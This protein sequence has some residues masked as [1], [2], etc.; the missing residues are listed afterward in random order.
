[1]PELPSTSS[2]NPSAHESRDSSQIEVATLECPV[3]GF[4]EGYRISSAAQLCP[5]CA[6]ERHDR[7]IQGRRQRAE[8][9]LRAEKVKQLHSVA[10][11]PKL[12]K[13][14][15]LADYQVSNPGQRYAMAICKAFVDSW[16]E[17]CT[18]GGT[19]LLL[20][21]CGTGKTHLACAIANTVIAE[22]MSTVCFGTVTDYSREV[23]S[24]FSG[25]RGATEKDVMHLLRSV[26]LL[27]VDE[28]GAHR[29]TEHEM[30][31]LFDIIDGRWRDEKAT[32]VISNLNGQ[33]LEEF[34]GER[35][36]E[37]LCHRG[38]VIAFD[39]ESHRSRTDT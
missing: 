1:M 17:Q 20:G 31:M 4:Y 10:G 7:E 34:I 8:Q 14:L 5:R 6:D 36:M 15:V 33:K 12:F 22:H 25:K 18:K 32:I 3:H 11:I 35:A 38:P 23:R 27:I 2:P 19:L 39:W 9:R 24:T 21:K 16:A 28:V 13:D 30:S 37:R 26:D 29:G